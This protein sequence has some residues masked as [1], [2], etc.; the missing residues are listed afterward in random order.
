MGRSMEKG[1]PFLIFVCVFNY[2]VESTQESCENLTRHFYKE[3]E[4]TALLQLGE[5][6]LP[7]WNSWK[8]GRPKE[9]AL[10]WERPQLGLS[11][12]PW[13]WQK[14]WRSLSRAAL[15]LLWGLQS[16]W[17]EVCWM[18]RDPEDDQKS[19]LFSLYPSPSPLHRGSVL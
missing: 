3:K 10:W 2:P 9:K 4:L 19:L 5:G 14:A 1:F 17:E 6:S 15:K 12:G 7:V 13:G 8:C 16:S 18:S 11:E